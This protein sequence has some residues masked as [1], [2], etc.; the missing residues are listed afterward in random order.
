M[1][2]KP[3]YITDVIAGIIADTQNAVPYFLPDGTKNKTGLTMLQILQAVDPSITG[4][5]YEFGYPPEI[6]ALVTQKDLA[7]STRNQKYPC[8]FLFLP[9]D[10]TISDELGIITAPD[11]RLAIVHQSQPEYTPRNRYDNVFKPVLYPIYMEF[12]N[13]MKSGGKFLFEGPVI[14]HTKTDYPYYNG[15]RQANV[16]NDFC[17]A[18]EINDLELK[19]YINN[20]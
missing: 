3:I 7:R 18:I 11:V 2:N 10:E 13:Q 6:A 19:I 5:H 1:S 15:E 12:M 14:E 9:I 4:I 16:A 20:C 17:D 8:I